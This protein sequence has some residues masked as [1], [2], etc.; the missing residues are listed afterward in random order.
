MKSC[1]LKDMGQ[2]IFYEEYNTNVF[3][4]QTY[5]MIIVT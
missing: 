2:I 5:F 1:K 4:L 3:I